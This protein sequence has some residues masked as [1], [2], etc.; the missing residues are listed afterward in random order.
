[1]GG[2]CDQEREQNNDQEGE[3]KKDVGSEKKNVENKE[4]D[5]TNN[6]TTN[7]DSSSGDNKISGEGVKTDSVPF[8]CTN[9][10]CTRSRPGDVSGNICVHAKER[11]ELEEKERKEK[12]KQQKEKEKYPEILP[13]GR[14]FILLRVNYIFF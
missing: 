3:E 4:G 11:A 10:E 2:V 8:I 13:P 14:A 5:T 1:M 7:T 12:E 9:P 6:N